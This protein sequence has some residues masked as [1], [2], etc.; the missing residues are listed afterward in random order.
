[1]KY[2]QAITC[3]LQSAGDYLPNL[4]ALVQT[5]VVTHSSNGRLATAMETAAATLRNLWEGLL[6]SFFL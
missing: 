5:I 3:V 6:I 2:F 1:M 4:L